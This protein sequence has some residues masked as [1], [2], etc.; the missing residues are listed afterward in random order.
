MGGQHG[1]TNDNE[2]DGCPQAREQRERERNRKQT[3][4]RNKIPIITGK[5]C[6]EFVYFREISEMKRGE[7]E[8]RIENVGN[9]K[10]GGQKNP[11]KPL[12]TA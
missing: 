4:L 1:Q 11:V 12:E 3:A 6:E 5:N 10:S 8:R 9:A 7:R 2:T